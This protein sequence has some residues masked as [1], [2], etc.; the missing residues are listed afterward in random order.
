MNAESIVWED[1]IYPFIDTEDRPYMETTWVNIHHTQLNKPLTVPIDD[2]V[3]VGGAPEHLSTIRFYATAVTAHKSFTLHP[4]KTPTY[5]RGPIGWED[6]ITM[7]AGSFGSGVQILLRK[8]PALD[9]TGMMTVYLTRVGVEPALVLES[10][11]D[12]VLTSILPNLVQ[13][14]LVPG[15]QALKGPC[16]LRCALTCYS[17]DGSSRRIHVFPPH[18]YSLEDTEDGVRV[19]FLSDG[20]GLRR[21][22]GVFGEYPYSPVRLEI[23]WEPDHELIAGDDDFPVYGF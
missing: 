6:S 7:D 11:A 12:S 13:G 2:M 4:E 21:W 8:V 20:L 16:V 23:W 14:V 5:N 3:S 22:D 9:E 17:D 19:R 18:Q 1:P 10:R 15:P